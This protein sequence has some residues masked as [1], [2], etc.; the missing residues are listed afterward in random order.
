MRLTASKSGALFDCAYQFRDGL[1]RLYEP[2]GPAAATGTLLHALAEAFVNGV[3]D[4]PPAPDGA[5]PERAA[6]MLGQLKAWWGTWEHNALDWQTEVPFALSLTTGA[7]RILPSRGPRDYA[8]ASP[9]EVTGTADLVAVLSD[10]VKVY[11]FKTTSRPD[12][13]ER[14]EVNPQLRTLALPASRVH[15]RDVAELGLIFVNE[16]ACTVDAARVDVLDLDMHEDRLRAAVAS[17]PNI[18]PNPGQHCRFCN[19]RMDCKA[20]PAW[21]RKKRAA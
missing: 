9:D 2:S 6:R 21:A 13:T 3:C 4:E 12:L 14:A 20:S 19:H 15:G 10:H 1:K 17:V 16:F 8:A 18:E 11:D 7:A 5:D